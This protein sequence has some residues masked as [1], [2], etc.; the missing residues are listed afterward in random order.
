MTKIIL[1]TDG[2][3][4]GNPG[5]AGVGAVLSDVA[6][7]PLKTANKF[8]GETTNNEAEY[9]GVLLGLELAKKYLGKDKIKDTEIEVRVDSELIARQLRGD[10][11]V[12]EER[13]WPYFMVVWNKR[14][15]EFKKLSF[16]EIPRE[17]NKLADKLANEAMDAKENGNLF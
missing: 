3:S 10:Y 13:L 4:R 6:G 14:V 9:Q 7:N 17:E 12:K 5:P 8:I 15:S 2:G 16:V 11:Q 1:N